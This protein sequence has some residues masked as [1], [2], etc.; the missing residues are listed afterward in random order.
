M[1]RLR[2]IISSWVVSGMAKLGRVCVWGGVV[3][4]SLKAISERRPGAGPAETKTG[5]ERG[6]PSPLPRRAS[7]L[8]C[9]TPGLKDPSCRTLVCSCPGNQ[10][11]LIHSELPSPWFGEE[12]A[13]PLVGAGVATSLQSSGSAGWPCYRF[14]AEWRQRPTAGLGSALWEGRWEGHTASSHRGSAASLSPPMA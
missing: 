1:R 13:E 6:Q 4:T 12:T 5:V 3:D 7:G 2:K 8:C 14:G 9:I 11:P 10:G